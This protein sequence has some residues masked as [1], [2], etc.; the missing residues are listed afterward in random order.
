MEIIEPTDESDTDSRWIVVV[1]RDE[2]E[3]AKQWV[4]GII[5]KI[6]DILTE[7][8]YKVFEAKFEIFPPALFTNAPLGGK[9]QK[10]TNETYER[11]MARKDRYTKTNPKKTSNAWQRRTPIFFDATPENF[12]ALSQGKRTAE[13]HQ[14]DEAPQ[15]NG[16]CLLTVCPRL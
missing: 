3:N 12:P 8:D 2:Y 4:A 10:E 6:P 5:S 1:L 14:N 16:Y 13:K 15:Q 9:M 11:V 7:F